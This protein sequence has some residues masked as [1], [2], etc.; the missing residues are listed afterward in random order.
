VRTFAPFIAGL[1]RMRYAR[2]VFFD[3][4]GGSIWVFGLTGAGYWF[5]NM[6]VVKAN[7]SAVM[8]GIIVL[9]LTPIAIGWLKQRLSQ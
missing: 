8:M 2:Y 1:S 7:L 6:P 5:G 3:A 4:I 9:S